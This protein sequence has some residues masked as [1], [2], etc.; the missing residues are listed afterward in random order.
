MI[1]AIQVMSSHPVLIRA[2]ERILS[3]V[4]NPLLRT[5][6]STSDEAKVIR[7]PGSPC[8][9]IL[10]ACSLRTG[11]GPLAVRF[12]A[13]SPGSKFLVLLSSEQHVTEE[14]RLFNWGIDGFV[15]LHKKWQRELPL[16]IDSI[17]KGQLWVSHHV[18]LAFA[19]RTKAL[20]DAQLLHG[21]FLTAREVEVAQ[22]LMRNLTNK[23][24][25]GALAI[26]ERTVKF[27][28]SN[29]LSKLQIDNRHGLSSDKLAVQEFPTAKILSNTGVNV[30]TR[31][32]T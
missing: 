30:Q 22:L 27:H 1:F 20:L 31:S 24:I 7:Q 28:V 18:L 21:H 8:L 4:K 17:L 9:F 2:V 13:D 16:A 12:R 6:P 5:L 10:D 29:I 3:R 23:E 19:K 11:L 32:T 26:S 25:S 15:E 14:I